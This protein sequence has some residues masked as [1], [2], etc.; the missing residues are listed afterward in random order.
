M[1]TSQTLAVHILL[2]WA[3]APIPEVPETLENSTYTAPRPHPTD[4]SVFFDLVKIRKAVDEATNLAVRAASGVTSA[5][6]SSSLNASNGMI[7]SAGA[8][9][10]GLGFGGNS[11]GPKLSRSLCK[12]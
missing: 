5:P 4:P 11:G 9:A 8:T 10:L 1:F 6:L 2:L 7:N 12:W 3:M